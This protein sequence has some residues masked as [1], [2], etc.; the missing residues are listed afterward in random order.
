M[1]LVSKPLPRAS[2]TPLLVALASLLVLRSRILSLPK[3]I[4]LKLKVATRGKPLKP[5]ELARV[6]QQVYVLREDGGETLLVPVRDRYVSEVLLNHSMPSCHTRAE[7]NGVQP[8]H[9]LSIWRASIYAYVRT[10]ISS[11]L[12]FYM[13][14]PSRNTNNRS[15]TLPTSIVVHCFQTQHRFCLPKTTARYPI[16]HRHS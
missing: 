11:A 12:G 15:I 8:L 14:D 1:A 6:L 16:S 3:D 13:F 10:D 9:A 4:L 2:R 5:E 7:L